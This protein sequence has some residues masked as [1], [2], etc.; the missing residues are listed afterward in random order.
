MNGSPCETLRMGCS[1]VVLCEG[2]AHRDVCDLRHLRDRPHGQHEHRHDHVRVPSEACGGQHLDIE[3]S[4]HP[5]VR[6][7]Q[8]HSHQEARCRRAGH[9]EHHHQRRARA[10]ARAGGR[11]TQRN[12]QDDRCAHG[13]QQQARAVAQCFAYQL[14]PRHVVLRPEV[15]GWMVKDVLRG[16]AQRLPRRLQRFDRKVLPSVLGEDRVPMMSSRR[17]PAGSTGCLPVDD[18]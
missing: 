10:S 15:A 6:R 14:E 8:D 4:V 9:R 12:S 5:D 1:N 13:K 11:H 2:F 18:R 3:R 16:L 17:L 7:P